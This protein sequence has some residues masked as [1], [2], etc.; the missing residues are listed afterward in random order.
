VLFLPFHQDERLAE[1]NIVLPDGAAA[2]VIEPPLPDG[3]R[4]Q[5]LLVLFDALAGRVAEQAGTRLVVTG[6]CLAA[7][8]TL[9]GLQRVELDPSVVWF[10]AHGDVHTLASST[11]GYLGGL[12][13]RMVLG[14]DPDRLTGPLG[15]RPVPEARCLLVDARDL[16]PAERDYL[17]GSAVRRAAVGGITADRIPDGPLLVHF[18][19]DVVDAAELP[20]LRF[21]VADGPGGDAVVEA[22]RRLLATGR[23]VALEIAAPWLDPADPG[24][25]AARTALLDRLLA[26]AG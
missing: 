14:G 18:D 12:A 13:L 16:D 2:D 9:T 5:R 4:W 25:T 1:D 17:A 11:S 19:L 24:Q 8:G 10:D 23:V 7:A 26:L 15:T 3:D 20:R 6:D 22:I 21:P